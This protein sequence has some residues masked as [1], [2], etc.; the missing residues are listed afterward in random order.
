MDLGVVYF[1]TNRLNT[2]LCLFDTHY[3]TISLSL[4]FDAAAHWCFRLLDRNWLCAGDWVPRYPGVS[5]WDKLACQKSTGM[6]PQDHECRI[7]YGNL[8]HLRDARSFC[9]QCRHPFLSSHAS[10][11][12]NTFIGHPGKHSLDLGTKK[13]T[14]TVYSL[15]SSR[16][17]WTVQLYHDC[18]ISMWHGHFLRFE[19]FNCFFPFFVILAA[20]HIPWRIRSSHE[21][22]GPAFFWVIQPCFT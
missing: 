3:L 16:V 19:A 15:A 4:L 17:K 5:Q 1:Q 18:P 13:T 2:F 9:W 21:L 12:R 10:K 6:G 7:I 11:R 20:K 8:W 14:S 22:K